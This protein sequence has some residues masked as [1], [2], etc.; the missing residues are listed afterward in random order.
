VPSEVQELRAE[1]GG[2]YEFPTIVEN[3]V[4]CPRSDSVVE[5]DRQGIPMEKSEEGGGSYEPEGGVQE[6][7]HGQNDTQKRLIVVGTETALFE[8]AS[9]VRERILAYTRCFSSVDFIVLCK[10]GFQNIRISP[11]VRVF[12]TNS[13]SGFT[14]AIDA[15]RI[16]KSLERPDVVTVQDPFESGIAGAFIAKHHAAPL[17]VQVHTDLFSPFFRAHSL[18]NR[19]RL[20]LAKRVL[21]RA[22]RIRV[23]SDRIGR[24]IRTTV[25]PAAPV[26][27]LPIFIDLEKFKNAQASDTLR[28]RFASYGRRLLVVS[29]LE[30]EKNI[31]L[32]LNA[33]ARAPQDSVLII[34]GSGRERKRLEERAAKL[35]ISG[36]VSFEGTQDPAPYYAIADLM[37]FP[38]HYDGYGRVIVE[39]LARGVPVLSTDVGVA[40]EMGAIVT[41]ENDFASALL[42]C[43]ENGPRRGS[44][45]SY[46]YTNFDQYVRAYC[47]D[48]IACTA[49]Q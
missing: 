17:H 40:K 7:L 25:G 12:P 21:R 4:T 32:A 23:V 27:V 10:S 30:S 22:A 16:G 1:C 11:N 41:N 19:I 34:V 3:A 31:G 37:L 38:S 48:I 20:L 2:V 36:R 18:I 24:S 42:S 13:L 47:D 35:G 5:Y 8:A 39:A 9:P 46:P 49:Q 45:T 6:S 33:F 15:M 29:R 14:C 26:S 43:I 44:L 28:S